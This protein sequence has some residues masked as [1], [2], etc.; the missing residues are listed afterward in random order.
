MDPK[1]LA[2]DIRRLERE[3]GQQLVHRN[4]PPNLIAGLTEHGRRALGPPRSCAPS[5]RR[6]R[7]SETAP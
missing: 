2:R 3:L 7:G 4:T 6:R 1:N 5:P